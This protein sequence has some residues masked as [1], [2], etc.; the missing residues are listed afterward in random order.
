MSENKIREFFQKKKI[1]FLP[2]I[3]ITKKAKGIYYFY[4]EE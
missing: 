2:F 1:L 4:E 3:N